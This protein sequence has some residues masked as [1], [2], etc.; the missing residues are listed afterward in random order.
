MSE[1]EYLE[2]AGVEK[3]IAGAVA[4]VLKERPK[5]PLG[6]IAEILTTVAAEAAAAA[7]ASAPAA[8]A[9]APAPAADGGGEG[10]GGEGGDGGGGK[11]EGE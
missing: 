4:T 1:R 3:A 10:G 9:A 2:S 7:E 8:E 5:D 6:R 11:S